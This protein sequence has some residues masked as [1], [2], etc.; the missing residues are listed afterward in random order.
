MQAAGGQS[1][2]QG[3]GHTRAREHSRAHTHTHSSTMFSMCFYEFR[4][5]YTNAAKKRN[6]TEK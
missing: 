5:P 2:L 3:K 1:H 6:E 4:K